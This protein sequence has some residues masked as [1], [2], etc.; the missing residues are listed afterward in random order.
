[1]PF[2]LDRRPQRRPRRWRND[3]QMYCRSFQ[4]ELESEINQI[5]VDFAFHRLL[6]PLLATIAV[7]AT[8]PTCRLP[9]PPC[10]AP[11]PRWRDGPALTRRRLPAV[12]PSPPTRDV[13]RLCCCQ[14]ATPRTCERPNHHRR[15]RPLPSPSLPPLPLCVPPLQRGMWAGTLWSGTTHRMHGGMYGRPRRRRRRVGGSG[16]QTN[17]GGRYVGGR[18]GANGSRAGSGC[19]LFPSCPIHLPAY[20]ALPAASLPSRPGRALR[21]H[22]PARRLSPHDWV[23]S[24]AGVRLP[25]VPPT[26][27]RAHTVGRSPLGAGASASEATDWWV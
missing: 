3:R 5:L 9:P 6:R 23:A 16:S 14:R 26:H 4:A 7:A 8:H 20:S 27:M 22:A 10:C 1:M 15:H 25:A 19:S 17:G 13:G 12:C 24:F 2:T 11:S 21:G 18:S